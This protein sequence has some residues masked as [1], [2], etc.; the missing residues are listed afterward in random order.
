MAM[1]VFQV[2]YLYGSLICKWD[3]MGG[4]SVVGVAC[5]YR[6]MT[7]GF[8]LLDDSLDRER[9]SWRGR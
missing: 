3:D 2:G 9:G 7:L 6:S 1:I 4:K 8:F 5:R